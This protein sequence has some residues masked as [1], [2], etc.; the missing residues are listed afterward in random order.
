MKKAIEK[1]TSTATPRS[2]KVKN[3]RSSWPGSTSRTKTPG[4]KSK[5]AKKTKKTKKTK[6][7]NNTA[8]VELGQILRHLCETSPQTREEVELNPKFQKKLDAA[9][10][11]A[12]KLRVALSD[13][14]RDLLGFLSVKCPECEKPELKFPHPH[15]THCSAECYLENQLRK[16]MSEGKPITP[17]FEKYREADPSTAPTPDKVQPSSLPANEN[18]AQIKY[19]VFC[20]VEDCSDED[21]APLTPN[22][23]LRDTQ[24]VL[25]E[26]INAQ[27]AAGFNHDLPEG[28]DLGL[29]VE[30]ENS[31][32]EFVNPPK[33][34]KVPVLPTPA[35][36][37]TWKKITHAMMYPDVCKAVH[38]AL[39]DGGD[40]GR[41][42][43]YSDLA[44]VLR[45]VASE[46]GKSARALDRASF[47]GDSD[48]IVYSSVYEALHKMA[49]ELEENGSVGI[50]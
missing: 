5:A 6:A 43:L 20:T 21:A 9:I 23:V 3:M 25:N 30:T 38:A 2:A 37:A 11:I 44:D 22:Q 8:W 13:R 45:D 40:D 34:G 19:T 41:K 48:I 29:E 26:A 12:E 16:A 32:V 31:S 15:P 42:S 50:I 24:K 49:T 47:G 39:T 14:G 46:F 18:G 28:N 10:A 17:I 36:E 35:G 27:Y 7:D 33:P 4:S 1:S